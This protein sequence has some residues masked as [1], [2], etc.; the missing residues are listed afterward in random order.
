MQVFKLHI[1]ELGFLICN[2]CSPNGRKKV[3]ND[4]L[5]YVARN[6]RRLL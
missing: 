4:E 3:Y 1:Q 2:S 6:R 5:K